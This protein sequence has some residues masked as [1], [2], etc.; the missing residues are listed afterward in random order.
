MCLLTL[1]RFTGKFQFQAGIFYMSFDLDTKHSSV[2]IF[3]FVFNLV[4]LSTWCVIK[5]HKELWA[6]YLENQLNEF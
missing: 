3:N 6:M 5:Q 4:I 2:V 1:L